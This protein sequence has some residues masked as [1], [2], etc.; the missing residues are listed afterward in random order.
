MASNRQKLYIIL[1]SGMGMLLSTLDTGIINV[2]LP[3]LQRQFNASTSVTALSVVGYTLSLAICILPFGYLGDRIGKLKI[4]LTGLIVFGIGSALCGLAGSI[5]TLILFRIIQGVGAAALQSTSAALVTTFIDKRQVPKALGILGIMI[6]LGPVLGPSIGGFLLALNAWR[7]I[8]WLNIPF[9]LLG[10]LCNYHLLVHIDETIQKKAFDRAGS[11]ISAVAITLLLSGF[12]L[13]GRNH[14]FATGASFVFIG[15]LAFFVF[16]Y[17]EKT[18]ASPLLDF[19]QL[20]KTPRIWLYLGETAVFGFVSA[21]IFLI[22]PYIFENLMKINTGTTGLLVLGAP[23]GLVIFSR[24]SGK[25]NDGS[26]NQSFSLL[27]LLIIAIALLGLALVVAS[28]PA[29]IITGLLFVFGIGGGYF[30]PA[31]IAAIMQTGSQTA[32][33]TLGSLQ[34]M[35]Q[36]IAIASG[37]SIG[38]SII[39]LTHPYLSS[40][41][42]ISWSMAFAITAG[43]LVVALVTS[44]HHSR[45]Y[46]K[47]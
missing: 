21:I 43:I 39:N 18:A 24:L 27:G 26:K 42:R 20:A 36:N 16:Y 45:Q 32:Q 8:F 30:Q 13:L 10:I 38:A 3:F 40:G 15:I 9:A 17:Y 44:K 41:I 6:G 12:S 34:R 4:S 47:G 2:A 25:Q 33:G 7:F 28:W 23:V 31:N 35:L 37:T 29:F 5:M 22:P 46:Y 14:H 19:K 1:I 11:I